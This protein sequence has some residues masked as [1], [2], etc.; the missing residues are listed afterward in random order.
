MSLP[1]NNNRY[2]RYKAGADV[3]QAMEMGLEVK[4][5]EYFDEASNSFCSKFA[6]FNFRANIDMPWVLYPSDTN[7]TPF[8]DGVEKSID[9]RARE[10]L[11]RNWPEELDHLEPDYERFTS[12]RLHSRDGKAK[13]L[14]FDKIKT[15]RELKDRFQAYHYMKPDVKFSTYLVVGL[16]IVCKKRTSEAP[17]QMALYQ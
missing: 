2:G 12:H 17:K 15:D 13:T 9:G 7:P 4:F 11:G 14:S 6:K 8:K 3:W 16:T 10:F 5:V 1:F